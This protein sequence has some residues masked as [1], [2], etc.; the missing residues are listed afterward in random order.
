MFVVRV[1]GGIRY[2]KVT[3]VQTCAL[4]ICP[5]AA[6]AGTTNDFR[7]NWT[8]G[9]TTD[10]VMG[11]WVGNDDNSPMINVS[12]IS[13]A[14]PIW[15]DA[16]LLAEQGHAIQDFVDPGGLAQ[17]TVTYPDG[18]KTTDWFLPGTVPTFNKTPTPTT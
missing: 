1:E 14:A 8:V 5:A 4:P 10:Y 17:A 12:G 16:M 9:Y 18:V 11:V 6:K 15:H 7:D 2:Y 13:G 3:G